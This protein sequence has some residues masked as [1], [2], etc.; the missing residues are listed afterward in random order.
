MVFGSQSIG[1][2]EVMRVI[3]VL[4]LLLIAL[5]AVQFIGCG[6]SGV[7]QVEDIA[8]CVV[9]PGDIQ[10]PEDLAGTSE[11]AKLAR[12][13]AGIASAQY[14]YAGDSANAA[15]PRLWLKPGGD[16][17]ASELWADAKAGLTD[18]Y[19]TLDAVPPAAGSSPQ[20]DVSVDA[21]AP[22][23][24]QWNSALDGEFL[25][26]AVREAGALK[27]GL[28]GIRRAPAAEV[29]ACTSADQLAELL[30]DR[31]SLD[32][33]TLL[34]TVYWDAAGSSD[35]GVLD[36]SKSASAAAAPDPVTDVSVRAVVGQYE[37]GWPARLT[38]DYNQ[39]GEVGVNDL[40]PLGILFGLSRGAE[41]S[42]WLVDAYARVD[43]NGDGIIG[44]S[45]ITPIGQNF[46][47]SCFEFRVERCAGDSAGP[48]S[49]W[50]SVEV[51]PLCRITST[52]EPVT[53]TSRAP[54]QRFNE[55]IRPGWQYYRVVALG[56]AGQAAAPSEI[57]P[58]PDATAPVWPNG[59]GV[60]GGFGG[61]ES[62]DEYI[63]EFNE[64]ATDDRDGD[65]DY[66]VQLTGGGDPDEQLLMVEYNDETFQ[67]E[68]H[69]PFTMTQVLLEDDKYSV[70]KLIQ[71]EE[72]FI[73][74]KVTDEAGNSAFSGWHGFIA[75]YGLAEHTNYALNSDDLT[76]WV[77]REGTV[78]FTPPN[79]V[80]LEGLPAQVQILA[81]V[82]PWNDEANPFY[83][84][85]YAG[86]EPQ[87]YHGGEV[88][89]DKV[90]KQDQKL[91]LG[92][93]YINWTGSSSFIGAVAYYPYF[94]VKPLTEAVWL[95]A[96]EPKRI[97]YMS[98]G[99]PY[100]VI[101]AVGSSWLA[102]YGAG[103]ALLYSL[104]GVP[105][106]AYD[107]YANEVFP[108]ERVSNSD[109]IIFHDEAFKTTPGSLTWYSLSQGVIGYLDE[110]EGIFSNSFG[111]SDYIRHWI[112][113]N[114]DTL[115]GLRSMVQEVDGSQV[116]ELW[117]AKRHGDISVR[118][119]ITPPFELDSSYVAT[120]LTYQDGLMTVKLTR[121][122]G[123]TTTE[124]HYCVIDKNGKWTTHD[125]ASS[126]PLSFD[127]SKWE[128][129]TNKKGNVY[130]TSDLTAWLEVYAEDGLE[131]D[132]RDRQYFH[133]LY[134]GSLMDGFES[135]T[136]VFTWTT[137]NGFG[138]SFPSEAAWDG[139][140]YTM[141]TPYDGSLVFHTRDDDYY[142]LLNESGQI[143]A[144]YPMDLRS[145]FNFNDFFPY[146]TK[147]GIQ[148]GLA[149][150]LLSDDGQWLAVGRQG[151]LGLAYVNQ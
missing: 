95:E 60:S 111:F 143:T 56:P 15:P 82:V 79:G 51:T 3:W 10:A 52:G 136:P 74:V 68:V 134:S 53:S 47:R 138:S 107:Q 106:D 104:D 145:G 57:V 144:R 18:L 16:G 128:Y 35:T 135:F 27:L 70:P 22:C 37:I 26:I 75:E 78:R 76:L 39:D 101:Y 146:F 105:I 116:L 42:A 36:V 132:D 13:A 114:A 59:P 84:E 86:I 120:L 17:E 62:G 49:E 7:G 46:G 118:M 72:Y 4:V 126:M 88:V 61:P 11:L 67:D 124:C 98:D 130:C 21:G 142:Y 66:A 103:T 147:S 48:S 77:N 100:S 91:T 83:E 32:G 19:V 41:A 109:T 141:L 54:Y 133:G 85:S 93:K 8:S 65:I 151:E 50:E 108:L 92:L 40:T 149:N 6:G 131:L 96:A 24:V 9:S 45:D 12:P 5:A 71:D 28:A 115:I 30:A 129:S 23:G 123:L 31:H 150:G 69:S 125:A 102:T 33:E 117:E 119:K 127:T 112:P 29:A 90:L 2:G 139:T 14:N 137:S 43:G 97:A 87:T 64:D 121:K 73:R 140:I 110:P 94:W 80:C 58:A 99:T 55:P 38:A 34:C 44:V 113:D 81:R 148:G 25:T 1:A 122:V 63:F 89:L 20:S